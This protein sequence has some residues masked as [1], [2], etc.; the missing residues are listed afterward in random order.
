MSVDTTTRYQLTK[1]GKLSLSKGQK[2][3][4]EKPEVR[5]HINAYYRDRT[6]KI[7]ELRH[8]RDMILEVVTDDRV[9]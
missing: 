1:K 8:P 9:D 3:Y 4:R 7:R 2:T 6:K 5:E